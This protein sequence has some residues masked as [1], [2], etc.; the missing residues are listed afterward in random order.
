MNPKPPVA[1][2]PTISPLAAKLLEVVRAPGGFA[3][4]RKELERNGVPLSLQSLGILPPTD[5]ERRQLDFLPTDGEGHYKFAVISDMHFGHKY[6]MREKLA[7]FVRMAYT[8]G[9]R[10]IF[11]PGD[12]LEGNDKHKS[13]ELTSYDLPGQIDEMLDGLPQLDG[14]SYHGITGN[15]DER[16]KEATGLNVGELIEMKARKAGRSDLHLYGDFSATIELLIA[17]RKRP[18]I[19]HLAHPC[20]RKIGSTYAKSYG[21]QRMAGQYRNKPH[22]TLIGHFHFCNFSFERGVKLI[23]CPTWKAGNDS[24][25]RAMGG[26]G[27]SECGGLII[28][29]QLSEKGNMR[30]FRPEYIE[31]QYEERAFRVRAR[32][33]T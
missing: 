2:A 23:N 15:H 27:S 30:R 26:A 22:I 16:F 18:L 14:L 6:C 13:W 12:W 8:E 20:M 7:S 5:D 31:A 17:G 25:G 29:F 11:V 1:A 21:A 28:D 33:S 3:K 19:V 4:I 24:L 32:S 10:V 9:V